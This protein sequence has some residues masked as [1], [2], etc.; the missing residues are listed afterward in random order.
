[1]LCRFRNCKRTAVP[2]RRPVSDPKLR[3]TTT[4]ENCRDGWTGRPSSTISTRPAAR[5]Q[6]RYATAHRAPRE[7]SMTSL[8]RRHLLATLGVGP[9]AASRAFATSPSEDIALRLAQAQQDGKV[10][11]LHTLLVSQGGRLVTE[12]LRAGRGRGL[13]TSARHCHLCAPRTARPALGV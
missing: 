8:N 6:N 13:G 7:E 4:V 5:L 2:S 10:D 12:H 9:M 3:F 1:M 11:G